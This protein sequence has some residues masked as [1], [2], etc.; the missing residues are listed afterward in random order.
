MDFELSK[1]I[2]LLER[3]PAVMDTWLRDLPDDWTTATEGGDTW[4]PYDVIGHLIHGEHTDWMARM[5]IILSDGGNKTFEPYDRFAQFTESK[6]K[7]LAQLLDEFKTLR[8]NNIS[9][10]KS[11]AFFAADFN[12]KGIHPKFGEV[13]L[14]QLLAAWV[15]HDMD[16]IYQVS[17]VMAKQY[18]GAVGPWKE[19]MRII[20]QV[21]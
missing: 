7:T 1:A 19:Y 11:K 15:V 4:S 6:G 21:I 2:A 16:H 20:N 13:T 18:T 9:F 8:A 12:K 10:L 14:S 17:R 3:T 5:N